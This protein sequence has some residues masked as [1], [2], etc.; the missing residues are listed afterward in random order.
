M[1]K[2]SRQALGRKAMKKGV[3]VG[4]TPA[5]VATM[6]TYM[7]TLNPMGNRSLLGFIVQMLAVVFVSIVYGIV[8]MIVLAIGV[9]VIY[10]LP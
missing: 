10:R 9:C 4:F 7:I 3:E 8:A 1:L 5:F 6:V 2:I